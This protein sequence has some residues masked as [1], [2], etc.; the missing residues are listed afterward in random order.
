MSEKPNEVM[1][2]ATP[3]IELRRTTNGAILFR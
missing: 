2:I 1:Q 3:A